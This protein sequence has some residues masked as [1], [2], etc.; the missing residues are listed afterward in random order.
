MVT[1]FMTTLYLAQVTSP[2]LLVRTPI[3]NSFGLG[4]RRL[5]SLGTFIGFGALI[6]RTEA[7]AGVAYL[8][9]VDE[10]VAE[11]APNDE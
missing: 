10:V 6:D 1:W 3:I 11:R 7:P 2:N 4:G 8:R 9:E 5:I